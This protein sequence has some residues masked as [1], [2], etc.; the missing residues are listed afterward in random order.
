[1]KR[2]QF[3]LQKALELR[4]RREND[5]KLELGRA[6]GTLSL[7][8]QRISAVAEDRS[9]ATAERFAP[10]NDISTIK[11][12]DRYVLRLDAQ[13]ETL[14]SAAEKAR[15][16]VDEAREVFLE[17]S[18]DRKVLDKVKERRMQE[19]RKLRL[20]DETKTTDDIAQKKQ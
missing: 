5:A 6:I 19:Y 14:L 9:R 13:K 4:T 3:K 15:G 7:L 16:I 10:E 1:M 18:R 20:M 12:Y 17:T 2:F 11:Q 8:E